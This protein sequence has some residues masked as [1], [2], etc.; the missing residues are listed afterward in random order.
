MKIENVFTKVFEHTKSEIL[1]N[2][3]FQFAENIFTVATTETSASGLSGCLILSRY[4]MQMLK[5]FNSIAT[6]F[7]CRHK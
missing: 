1:W 3:Y 6:D 2:D 7:H 4:R 5:G